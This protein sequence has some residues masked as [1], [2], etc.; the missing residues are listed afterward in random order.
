MPAHPPE[1]GLRVFFALWPTAGEARAMH[2]HARALA[3][4]EGRIMRADTLHLTL[5]FIGTVEPAQIGLLQEIG[6]RQRGRRFTLD[7]DQ[8]GHWPHKG[9]VWAGCRS[10]PGAL[11]DLAG[12]LA[13]DLHEAGFKIER[14]SFRPHVT[15]LRNVLAATPQLP[16]PGLRWPVGDF[17]LVRS[18]PSSSGSHYTVVDRFALAT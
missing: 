14:R 8:A 16:P 18:Q 9:I 11:S 13:Q 17:V 4:G 3:V 10:V 1:A 12:E 2:R 5:A 15:L 7:L 6:R